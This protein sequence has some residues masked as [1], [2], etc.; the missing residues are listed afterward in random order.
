MSSI[1]VVKHIYQHSVANN[2]SF[3]PIVVMMDD[4]SPHLS[5]GIIGESGYTILPPK[6]TTYFNDTDNQT[7]VCRND[8]CISDD[9]YVDM[10]QDFVFPT[11]YEWVLIGLYMIVFVVGVIG[12]F[13]VCFAVWRNQHM[14]TVTNLFIVNLAVADLMVILICLPPTVLGDVTETWYI[15]SVMCKIVMYSQVSANV[16]T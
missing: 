8:Y 2:D 10:I 14:H 7:V 11:K 9:A 5:S 12:N 13:L 4:K 6:T 15:G 3:P 16:E 1:N